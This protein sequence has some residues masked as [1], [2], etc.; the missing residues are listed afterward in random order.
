MQAGYRFFWASVAF[1]ALVVS[2][3][4]RAAA[5]D[6]NEWTRPV[7]LTEVNSDYDDKAAFLSFDGSTLYLARCTV[8]EY[9]RIFEATRKAEGTWNAP[10]EIVGLTNVYANVDYPWVSADNLRLSTAPNS[11]GGG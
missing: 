6:P 4:E 8:T 9:A 11:V 7:P 2:P 3:W 5:F 1:L 10:T